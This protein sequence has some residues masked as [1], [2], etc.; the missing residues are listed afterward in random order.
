MIVTDEKSLVL[1]PVGEF[2]GSQAFTTELRTVEEGREY[3]LTITPKD[4]A[5]TGS[6]FFPFHL[7]WVL[8][9]GK[10]GKPLKRPLVASAMVVK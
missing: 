2:K 1:E 6:A 3:E 4:T 9:S 5:K 7:R 10:H 8:D